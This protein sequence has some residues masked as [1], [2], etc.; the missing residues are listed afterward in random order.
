MKQVPTKQDLPPISKEN[1]GTFYYIENENKVYYATLDKGYQS[2]ENNKVAANTNIE[3]SLYNMNQQII[4]QLGPVKDKNK[5]AQD[6]NEYQKKLSDV[7]SFAIIG[8]ANHYFTVFTNVECGPIGEI[9]IECLENVGT[10]YESN[11]YEGTYELWVKRGEEPVDC[12]T[13]F[14]YDQGVID[15][16]KEVL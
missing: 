14:P 8:W 1:N 3:V 12:Y 9:V 7:H 4:E 13:L 5:L 10:I 16:S 15:M 6:I 2:I 11:E